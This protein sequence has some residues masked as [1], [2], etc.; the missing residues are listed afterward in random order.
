VSIETDVVRAASGGVVVE[1]EVD[2]VDVDGFLGEM[3]SGGTDVDLG[4]PSDDVVVDVDD[5]V[6]SSATT[7][8][9][10]DV[11]RGDVA[12]V[13]VVVDDDDSN[14]GGG[15]AGDIGATDS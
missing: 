10:N 13:V 1:A 5:D 3:G 15:E 4:T 7:L 9:D 12:V 6:D 2:D 11:V 14:F 8:V